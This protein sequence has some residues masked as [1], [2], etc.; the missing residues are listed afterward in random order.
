MACFEHKE[1]LFDHFAKHHGLHQLK[2]IE[3]LA[4]KVGISGIKNHFAE[5]LCRHCQRQKKRGAG[6]RRRV[7]GI[8]KQIRRFELKWNALFEFKETFDFLVSET[9]LLLLFLVDNVRS[10]YLRK[11]PQASFFWQTEMDFKGI[12]YGKVTRRW[13][14]FA[15]DEFWK[16]VFAN[17]EKGKPVDMTRTVLDVQRKVVNDKGLLSKLWRVRFRNTVN[18]QWN[19]YEVF[20]GMVLE[21]LVQVLLVD[22]VAVV[23][24]LHK[25]VREYYVRGLG[26]EGRVYRGANPILRVEHMMRK[27]FIKGGSSLL[28]SGSSLVKYGV[29]TTR[30]D[31]EYAYSSRMSRVGETGQLLK[32]L[33]DSFSE[34]HRTTTYEKW[35]GFMN[36]IDTSPLFYQ[37]ACPD[38]Q[39]L[40][41]MRGYFEELH[42]AKPLEK[43]ESL[44]DLLVESEEEESDSAGDDFLK[45]FMPSGKKKEESGTSGI[46]VEATKLE[47]GENYLDQDKENRENCG[48]RKTQ[49][50][51]RADEQV[52]GFPDYLREEE[53]AGTEEEEISGSSGS[54]YK[55]ESIH[56]QKY[57]SNLFG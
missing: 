55:R 33:G 27:M 25:Y 26:L 9:P 52:A 48:P 20:Y 45:N 11:K 19:K 37:R 35:R 51:K 46:K 40:G 22:Q 31:S 30:D 39:G 42:R 15:K 38:D 6:R 17:W 18:T 50:G 21:F 2:K 12:F 57:L 29:F 56:S 8:F 47:F 43:V 53:E 1:D 14:R 7:H 4:A 36:D 10:L 24:L 5:E 32:N 3:S 16:K 49:L 41:L 54:L 44:R 23:R 28:H 34:S 13:R